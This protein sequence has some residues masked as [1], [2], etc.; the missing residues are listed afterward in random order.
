MPTPGIIVA[1]MA[2]ALVVIGAQKTVHG[3]KK[4]GH[5]IRCIAKTGHKCAPK[6]QPA[7]AK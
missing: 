2:V 7:T 6:P 3:V 4:V 5:H 1:A